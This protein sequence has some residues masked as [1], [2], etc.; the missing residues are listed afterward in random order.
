MRTA[1]AVPL[2]LSVAAPAPAARQCPQQ[3]FTPVNA[4]PWSYVAPPLT[5]NCLQTY[6]LFLPQTPMPAEGYPVVI[7][8]D[9]ASFQAVTD[10]DTIAPFKNPWLVPLLENGVA[11]VA[12]RLT[13]SIP[14]QTQAHFDDWT[15]LCGF[16]PPA[17]PG[18]GMF[19]PPGVM[20]PDMQLAGA[21]VPPVSYTHLTLPTIYSV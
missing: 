19:H 1:L 20:P 6:R 3:S 21:T 7:Y 18:H 17:I 9:L 4:S 16:V 15:L 11:V 10:V 13:V 12:A 8:T 5:G 14:F 2:F